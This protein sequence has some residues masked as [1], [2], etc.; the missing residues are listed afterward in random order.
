MAL[1]SD[2]LIDK[3]LK[4]RYHYTGTCRIERDK[5]R[6]LSQARE[7]RIRAELARLPEEVK[8]E[9]LNKMIE[10]EQQI[11]CVSNSSAL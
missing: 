6:A 11:Q 5:V 9:V 1:N 3:F 8:R 7:K 10:S 2:G 4:M